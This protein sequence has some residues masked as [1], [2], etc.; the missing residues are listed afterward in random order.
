DNGGEYIDGRVEQFLAQHGIDHEYSPSHEHES[1]GVAERFNRTIV[2]KARTML[3]D[4][5]N[6]TH[7]AAAKRVLRYLQG[8]VDWTLHF[9]SKN[10]SKLHGFSDSSYGNFIDDRKSCTGYVF[11]LGEACISWCSKKQNT[12]A[13]STTEAEYMAASDSARHMIWTKNALI[14]LEQHYEPIL[15]VDSNG[16]IDLSRN[17]KISQRSKHIDIRY[18]FIRSHINTTFKLEYI[19]SEENI[20]DLLTKSLA[21]PAHQRLSAIVR[22]SPEGK[23]R[24]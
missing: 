8:T 2:T 13:L 16:A 14:E 5:P 20:A 6:N 4:F 23:C 21:K 11:R 15:H 9:P 3:I 19:P 17:N 18:H 24:N 7:L 1:N 22:C 10:D 12:V